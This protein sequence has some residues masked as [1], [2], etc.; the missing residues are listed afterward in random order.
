M[1]PHIKTLRG[2]TDAIWRN[3][4]VGVTTDDHAAIT[5]GA[6]AL[7]CSPK[8]AVRGCGKPATCIGSYE[9]HTPIAPACDKCCGHGNED[10]WCVPIAD[11]AAKWERDSNAS[12]EEIGKLLGEI[13]E[14]ELA[15]ARLV[16]ELKTVREAFRASYPP[17]P[18]PR[19]GPPRPRSSRPFDDE[20]S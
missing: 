9:G 14:L 13:V 12:G 8:C 20:P 4:S 1:S 15:N 10:G 3:A 11:A 2:I 7:D 19:P 5:A 17:D 18:R 16:G 6:D